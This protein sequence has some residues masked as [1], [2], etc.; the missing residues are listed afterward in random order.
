MRAGDSSALPCCLLVL[1]ELDL[2]KLFL[3]S[4]PHELVSVEVHLE[5]KQF[6][7]SANPA[8][9]CLR[10]L[11]LGWVQ[12]EA[13]KKATRFGGPP[14]W[15][16]VL[17]T[18]SPMRDSINI[19][20]KK[21]KK[22]LQLT[23]LPIAAQSTFLGK[24]L[25][26]PRRKIQSPLQ[27]ERKRDPRGKWEPYEMSGFYLIIVQPPPK[28]VPLKEEPHMLLPHTYIHGTKE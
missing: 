18:S 22:G 6:R 25:W 28:G 13:K 2:P 8:K 10:V 19:V 26:S 7:C 27:T 16:S 15:R 12:R 23:G 5:L 14:I 11:F 3:G 21:Q 20:Q 1:G 9:A 24:K 17:R 4:S